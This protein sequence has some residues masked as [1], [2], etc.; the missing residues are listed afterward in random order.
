MTDLAA[1]EKRPHGRRPTGPYVV[2]TDYGCE[3]WHPTSYPSLREAVIASQPNDVVTLIPTF[4]VVDTTP[5][6]TT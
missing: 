3:G 6:E 1:A 5:P 2:W 4:E